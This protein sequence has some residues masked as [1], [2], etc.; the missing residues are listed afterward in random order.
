M[1]QIGNTP[2]PE[3]ATDEPA[4]PLTDG[5]FSAQAVQDEHPPHEKVTAPQPPA[6]ADLHSEYPHHE[7]ATSPAP[8]PPLLTDFDPAPLRYREDGLTPHKQREYVE[9]LADC[10]VARQAAARIGVSEQAIARVRRRADARAFDLA[11]EAAHRFGARN[12]RSI[13][14]ERAVQ[15]TVKRYYYHGELK[16]E[17]VV[18]DNRL[19]IYLLGKTAHL[20]EPRPETQ[21]VI[22]NWEPWMEA[23]EQG[24]PAPR[25]AAQPEPDESALEADPEE[26]LGDEVWRD[27]DG[28]WWTSF[29]PPAGFDGDEEFAVEDD[30]YRRRLSKAEE[31]VMN[32]AAVATLAAERAHETARRDRWFGFAGGTREPEVS[33]S[34]EAETYGTSIHLPGEADETGV[35]CASSPASAEPSSDAPERPPEPPGPRI[36]RL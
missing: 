13:A 28:S 5:H 1:E 23:I 27:D 30:L 9:A 22:D 11:C 24:L 35:P 31:A 19:L 29:P 16:S 4:S 17:E 33:S 12:L 7:G 8:L 20:A 21:Q 2:T 25:E 26:P 18:Y 15:G 14:Y 6:E 3:A 36:R 34:R 10:G 32:A